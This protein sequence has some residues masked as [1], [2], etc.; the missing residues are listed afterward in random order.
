MDRRDLARVDAQLGAEAVAARPGQVD[1]LHGQ[2][3]RRRPG[4]TLKHAEDEAA[5]GNAN[6]PGGGGGGGSA[7]QNPAPG[8]T[9]GPGLVIV[10]Y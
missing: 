6:G 8:G 2:Y 10:Y 1:K 4:A 3:P 9:G 5:G 7:G